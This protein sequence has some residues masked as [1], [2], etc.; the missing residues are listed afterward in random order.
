[1]KLNA[2]YSFLFKNTLL[3]AIANF[4]S[5]LIVFFLLPF[6]TAYL[7]TE[8]YAIIDLISVAQQLIFPIVTLDITEAVIRFCMEKQND[9]ASVF[10][11][12]ILVTV[13]GNLILVIGCT[14]AVALSIGNT[15]YIL[16][17]LAFNVILSTN[18]LLSSFY[19]TID[20]VKIITVSSIINTLLTTVLNVVLIAYLGMGLDGY[21]I[22]YIAGGL[23]GILI[24]LLS[25]RLGA[26]VRYLSKEE[27]KKQII[28]LVSYSVPLIP[29]ALFWWINSSLDRIFLTSM[30]G[31]AFAGMYAAANKIPVIL[32]TLSMIFQ[33]SWGLSLFREENTKEK[34][35]FFY[36][37]YKVYNLFLLLITTGL[38]LFS[39]LFCSFLLS[40]E[41]FNAWSWVPWLVVGFYTNSLSS[42]L[43][44]EFTAAK[45]TT[46]I[47]STTAVSALVNI[48]LNVLLIPRFTGLGAAVATCVS[49][50]VLLEMRVWS[51]NKFFGLKI[52]N[53]QILLLHMLL[54]VIV[55]CVTS[56]VNVLTV[57]IVGCC[58]LVMLCLE[59]NEVLFL[60]NKLILLMKKQ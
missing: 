38:V 30:S 14:S 55:F 35:S 18:T 56:E 34:R 52:D 22:S 25:T 13:I 36:E 2:R 24:M 8:E 4:S 10:T 51:L 1:M 23:A 44:T 54:L 6:Y 53:V 46:W 20:R 21:Y 7:T 27:V 45:K 26:Y 48:I 17:F 5:K 29:N 19:R 49:Y 32:S 16:Y 47:L 42:F 57:M 43:G 31:L 41:F 39:K 28:P 9:K 3:F 37:V 60:V 33:Q 58:L 12:G 40:K 59:K 11:I 15:R 50:A